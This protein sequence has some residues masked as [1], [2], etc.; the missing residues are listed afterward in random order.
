MKTTMKEK[1][2]NQTD[3]ILKLLLIISL[4]VIGINLLPL[5][6]FLVISACITAYF[7][8]K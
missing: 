6:I 8:N 4:I 3:L 1:T 7:L 5:E 2:K